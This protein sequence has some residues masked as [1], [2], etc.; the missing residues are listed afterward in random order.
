MV[1][2]AAGHHGED[3]IAFADARAFHGGQPA[4]ALDPA[5]AGQHDVGVFLD[6]VGFRVELRRLLAAGQLGPPAVAELFAQRLQLVLDDAPELLLRAQDRLDLLRLLRLLLQLVE[7]L[8]DFQLG[9]LVKLG[10]ENGV[11]LDLVELERLHQLL[12]RVRLA[13][14]LADHA[15]GPVERVEDDLEAFEDVDALA[16]LLQ[17]ELEAFANRLQAEIEE[18]AQDLLEAEPARLRLAVGVRHQAGQVDRESSPAEPCACRDR[19]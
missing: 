8:L 16:K 5:V 18:I 19:P 15:D 6:D 10:I 7:D 11:G 17:L 9:D 4:D 13:V 14:A 12:G 2:R 3:R 1:E